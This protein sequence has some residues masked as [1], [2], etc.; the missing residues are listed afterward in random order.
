MTCERVG[1]AIVCGRRTR[2]MACAFCGAPGATKLCDGPLPPGIIHRRSSTPG[3]DKT[4]SAPICDRCATHVPPDQD[5]C[6][7]HAAPENRRLAL[8]VIE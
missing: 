4:C 6:P 3:A 2:T 7:N 8:E 5:Y 1:N